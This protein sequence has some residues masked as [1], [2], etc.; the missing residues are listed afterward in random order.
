MDQILFRVISLRWQDGHIVDRDFLPATSIP[1]PVGNQIMSNTIQPGR[2]R[3][4]AIRIILDVI[5]CPLKNAGSKI[6]RV[7]E[8]P[9][10]I[11]NV[12]EDAVY[13]TFIKQTKR[14]AVTL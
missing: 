6:L 10:S 2:E 13:I 14:I 7:V 12:V 4:A 5:H 9:R 11:V 1:V 3:D 8:V